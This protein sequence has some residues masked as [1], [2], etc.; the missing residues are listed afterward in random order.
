M[1]VENAFVFLIGSGPGPVNFVRPWGRS[2]QNSTPGILNPE[3]AILEILDSFILNHLEFHRLTT[4][5]F[6]RGWFWARVSGVGLGALVVGLAA[7]MPG[8]GTDSIAPPPPE[9]LRSVNTPAR[10]PSASKKT[11]KGAKPIELVLAPRDEE[12]AGSTAN[13]AKTQAGY[14]GVLVHTVAP[15]LNTT[16]AGQVELVAAAIKDQ[17]PAL[18]VETPEKPDPQLSKQI[19]AAREKGIPVVLIGPPLE[20]SKESGA[21]PESAAN[22]KA[23]LIRIDSAPFTESAKQLVKSAIRVAKNAQVDPQG[24]ALLLFNETGDPYTRARVAA[25]RAALDEEG[26]KSQTTVHCAA[27]SN[28]AVAELLAAVQKQPKATIVIPFDFRAYSALM[29]AAGQLGENKTLVV[30]GYSSEDKN[31]AIFQISNLAATAE[32]RP[33]K[34]IRRGVQVAESILRGEKVDPT[35]TIPINFTDSS[36]SMGIPTLK[37]PK[38]KAPDAEIRDS[39]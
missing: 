21:S 27:D 26:I 10:P 39:K 14:D 30:V 28:A 20:G 7:G 17:P 8:C 23:P 33:A 4:E 2:S 38:K 24:G 35:I 32:F 19:E 16:P 1:V 36:P 25:I 15:G 9:G 31:L 22:K 18:I 34:L 6:M 29:A 12:A 5:G 11:E 37:R 3:P 13:F